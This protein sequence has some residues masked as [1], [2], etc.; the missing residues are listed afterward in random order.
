M[1]SDETPGKTVAIAERS[2]LSTDFPLRA[3]RYYPL[4]LSYEWLSR[5]CSHTPS[6]FRHRWLRHLVR[7]GLPQQLRCG[8]RRCCSSAWFGGCLSLCYY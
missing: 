7:T 2:A 1:R 5:R 8:Y 6:Q 4:M 3:E